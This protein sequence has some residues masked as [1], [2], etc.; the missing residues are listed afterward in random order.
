MLLQ[1][2]IKK[3]D[4]HIVLLKLFKQD[5][6][7]GVLASQTIWRVY[8]DS[9]NSPGPGDAEAP[10]SQRVTSSLNTE[11]LGPRETFYPSDWKRTGS[12]HPDGWGKERTV[13]EGCQNWTFQG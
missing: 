10:F 8:V 6:L 11:C 4:F 9:V 13:S 1:I 3:N 12:G 7:I 5:H 2:V